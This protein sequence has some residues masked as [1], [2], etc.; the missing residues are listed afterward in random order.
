MGSGETDLRSWYNNR[1]SDY[2]P[3]Y[4]K[5]WDL[6]DKTAT[7]SGGASKFLAVLKNEIIPFVDAHY[8]SNDNRGLAGFSL[9]GLFTAYCLSKNLN[10]LIAME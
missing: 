9:G 1:H 8:K 5:E 4:S 3:S 6:K 7:K 10:Y 2:T